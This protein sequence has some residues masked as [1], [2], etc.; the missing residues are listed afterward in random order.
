MSSCCRDVQRSS[1]LTLTTRRPSPAYIGWSVGPIVA[2]AFLLPF[3]L[4]KIGL[5]ITGL[6]ALPWLAWRYDNETGAFLRLAMLLCFVFLV[7]GLVLFLTAL[8]FFAG[9]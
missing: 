3:L 1:T 7:L 4:G 2:V 6:L 5:L 9:H 8:V